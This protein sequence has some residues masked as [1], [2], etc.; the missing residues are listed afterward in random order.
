MPVRVDVLSS[1]GDAAV[2]R[3]AQPGGRFG[4][5]QHD[6]LVARGWQMSGYALRANLTYGAVVWRL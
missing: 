1:E 3:R 4:P 2:W 5:A 6:A